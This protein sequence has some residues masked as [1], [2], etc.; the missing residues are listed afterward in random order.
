[1]P[2][3]TNTCRIATLASFASQFLVP[4]LPDFKARFPDV[5]IEFI[6][7]VRLV[8][9]SREEADI[10]V[11]YGLGQYDGLQSSPLVKGALSPVC[12]PG[13]YMSCEGNLERLL[14]THRRIQ[15]AGFNEWRD[16]S[17]AAGIDTSGLQP[18]WII[19]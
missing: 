7:S 18:A 5:A 6:T 1:R 14:A 13:V 19:E 9:L 2:P 3:R 15:S 4:R 17:A 8:D 12:A 11:R 10:G 16:W